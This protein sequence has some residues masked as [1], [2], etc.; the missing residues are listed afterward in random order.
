MT[1]GGVPAELR[2]LPLWVVV[3]LV[4]IALITLAL[5]AVGLVVAVVVT[6]VERVDVAAAIRAGVSPLGASSWLLTTV[7]PAPDW[8]RPGGESR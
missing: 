6:A 5:R 4:V 8:A 2:R 1:T 7:S 3:P